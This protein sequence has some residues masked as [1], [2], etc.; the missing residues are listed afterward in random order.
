MLEDMELDPAELALL[1]VTEESRRWTPRPW[2]TTIEYL[3][4]SP[5]EVGRTN[6]TTALKQIEEVV[7][8]LTFKEIPNTTQNIFKK[9]IILFT[10]A[11]DGCFSQVGRKIGRPTRV[12]LGS[13]CLDVVVIKHEVIHS[14]GFVH[15]HNRPDRD[16]FVKINTDKITNQRLRNNVEKWEG[17]SSYR[18]Y[19]P[20]DYHSIMHYVA[21]HEGVTVIKAHNPHYQNNIRIQNDMSAADEIALNRHFQCPTISLSQHERYMQ[22]HDMN[23]YHELTQLDIKETEASMRSY[24]LYPYRLLI[25]TS[26]DVEEIY[27]QLAGEYR[28]LPD[29]EEN[30]RPVWQHSN[31]QA[32][33]LVNNEKRWTIKEIDTAVA[34]SP[35]TTK[36]MLESSQE[37]EYYDSNEW[38]SGFGDVYINLFPDNIAADDEDRE[39]D[40]LLITGGYDGGRLSNVEMFDPS[41]PSLVCNLPDMTVARYDHASVG[42]LVC[43]G[44]GGLD[45]CEELSGA[46]WRV[47]HS[48]QQKRIYHVMWQTPSQEILVMGGGYSED[49]TERLQQSGAGW[50]L[51]HKTRYGDITNI[52][53][54]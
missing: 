44:W 7:T 46:K 34:R 18:L 51:K 41:N 25:E 53:S 14:V 28:K 1:G 16:S 35:I 36:N 10:R 52:V 38:V 15:E 48:L 47:S 19:T 9:E 26:E 42:G 32:L 21:E 8:C 49:T 4:D 29:V 30:G 3:I 6:I 50:K 43:G 11:Q 45:S 17:K 40:V 27:P 39:G 5:L 12:N 37:W 22:F 2:G 20:Y 33:K 54:I 23:F 31:H 13:G 24:I